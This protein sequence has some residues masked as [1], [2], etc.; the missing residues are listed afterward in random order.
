MISDELLKLITADVD[1]RL[2]A[3]LQK[4]RNNRP[5]T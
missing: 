2:S 4:V 5:A 1:G 3:S